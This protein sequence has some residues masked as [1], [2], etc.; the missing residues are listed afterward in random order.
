MAEKEPENIVAATAAVYALTQE[1]EYEKAQ[2]IIN[3]FIPNPDECGD[4]N[5]IMFTAAS[6]FYEATGNKK[7]KN[8]LIK[9]W[10]H[11]ISTWKPISPK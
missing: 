8:R 9:Q 6:K 5:D 3:Q 2:Q 11:M 4:E 10:K 7:A 1:K